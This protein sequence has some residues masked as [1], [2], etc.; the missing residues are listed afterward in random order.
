MQ[1]GKA[2]KRYDS[3]RRRR[4]ALTELAHM[5]QIISTGSWENTKRFSLEAEFER[6][7]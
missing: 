5:L 1:G 2:F 7:A 6:Q 4:T 3:T